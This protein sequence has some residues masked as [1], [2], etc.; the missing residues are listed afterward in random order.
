LKNKKKCS[1]KFIFFIEPL[2]LL[3]KQSLFCIRSYLKFNFLHMTIKETGWKALL[4][5]EFEK[6]YFKSIKAQL[7]E[8]EEKIYPK[9]DEIFAAFDLC[10]LD[11]TRVIILGQDPYHKPHE[12]MGLSFSVPNHIKVPP[13]L[14]NIFKEIQTDLN[15]RPSAHGDLRPWAK[16]GVLLLN[17]ILTVEHKKPASHKK[18]GWQ[19]FTDT[20]IELIGQKK[21]G[22]VFMLWG[23]YAKGKAA[24]LNSN[25]H[26]ILEASHPSPLARGAFFGCKHFSQANRYL[27]SNGMEELD[28]SLP[29]LQLF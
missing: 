8:S 26:L 5:E 27:Q 17:S 19:I 25:D 11:K 29:Q 3:N 18:I 22:L 24:L 20:C 7:K 23:N 15:I 14:R 2:S 12:A 21:K 28:W 1:L 13:S 9:K 4:T 16:Q 6:P 10:P